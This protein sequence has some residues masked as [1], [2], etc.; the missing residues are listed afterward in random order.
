MIY[1]KQWGNYLAGMVGVAGWFDIRMPAPF[2]WA[3]I[4]LAASFVVFAIAVGSRSDRWRFFVIIFGGV[5]VPGVLQVSQA[6]TVGFIIG[7]RYML[8][9]LVGLPLL[10]AFI[11]ERKLVNNRQ[12]RSL[13]KLFCLVLLPVHLVMLVYSMVRWQQGIKGHLNPFVGSWLPP[14]G[15]YLP[16]ILMIAGIA[17]TWWITVRSQAV[18][19]GLPDLSDDLSDGTS[20]ASAEAAEA[21]D[22]VQPE[23]ASGGLVV[24]PRTESAGTSVRTD[25]DIFERSA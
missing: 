6:N 16:V 23:R 18:P 7:G 20:A 19:A 15:P 12:S 8:P 9:L 3:W 17:V 21:A 24:R 13:T 1:F 25:E 11:L 4:S 14:N 22:A 2:Y 10:G 5:V